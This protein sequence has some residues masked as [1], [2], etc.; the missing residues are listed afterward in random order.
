M[1]TAEA[2]KT[3]VTVESEFKTRH[4]A[5]QKVRADHVTEV[6]ALEKEMLAENAGRWNGP[7]GK[8]FVVNDRISLLAEQARNAPDARLSNREALVEFK[9]RVQE[10]R[11]GSYEQRKNT[12]I[13]VLDSSLANRCSLREFYNSGVRAHAEGKWSGEGAFVLTSGALHEANR[14]IRGLALKF[15]NGDIGLGE[16]MQLPLNMPTAD[17]T[18]GRSRKQVRRMTRDAL[19]GDFPT[20]G[21]L[22]APQFIMPTIELLRNMPA[23]AKAGITFLT[24]VMGNLIL[25]RQTSPTTAQSVAEGAALLQYDQGF[26]QIRMNPHRVGTS[27]N[28]SRLALL[29]TTPDFEAL[30]MQDHLAQIALWIDQMVLNGQGAGDQPLGILNQMGIGVV[31]FGGSAINAYKNMVALETAIRAANIYEECSFITTSTARG[32]LRITP[33]V[34]TGS[35]IVSG[36]TQSLWVGDGDG[37]EECIGRPAVDSQ[38]VPNNIIVALVGRHVVCA[39]WGGLAVV[40]DTITRANQDEYRLSINTYIDVALR[41]AQAVARSTDS[42][43][44]LN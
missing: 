40:L 27:Q 21:A 22:V 20:A 16:G 13:G 37:G 23:M 5:A 11:T 30:V 29:Q 31:T 36:T 34:L 8:V 25:P 41:H 33:A 9:S 19:A 3:R 18:R 44:V 38:Q 35:T 28:Y 32:T 43:A 4:D 1:R 17:I 2:Q 6:N 10:A 14:E 15:P 12:E 39:Q 26:D 7:D 24:G 42:I